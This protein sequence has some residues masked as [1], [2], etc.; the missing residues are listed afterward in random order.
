MSCKGLKG[1]K[2][3]ECKKNTPT[4]VNF[5]LANQAR[6][7][8]EGV[9]TKRPATKRDSTQYKR[10]FKMGLKGLTLSK[11]Q[12]KNQGETEFHKMGRWEGQ[13]KNKKK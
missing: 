8:S 9:D 10:G 11:M 6:N 12:L 7:N 3:A 2:L 4:Y 1:K 13:N 5:A